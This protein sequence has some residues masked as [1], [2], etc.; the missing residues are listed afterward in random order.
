MLRQPRPSVPHESR[1][2]QVARLAYRMAQRT[3]RR[4]SHRN[5]PHTY[6][7]AQ[8]AA[9]TF[10]VF[11][12]HK[13]YRDGEELL[14]A[15]DS[16]RQ[17]LQLASVPDHSTLCRM[18][19]KLNRR[20]LL[21]QLRYLVDQ[22][23]AGEDYIALDSTS[24][25]QSQASSYFQTRRGG[26]LR[27]WY[28][29][30]YAVGTAS[31]LILAAASDGGRTLN[32]VCFLLPL[33]QQARYAA[34]AHTLF[35]ADAGFDAQTVDAHDVIPPIRRGN[36]LVAPARR[37]R[38]DLVSQ[39]RL[40]GLFGQRWKVETVNSVTKRLFGESV[41]SRSRRLKRREPIFKAVV[42]NLHR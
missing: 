8:V 35:L 18:Y 17:V 28:R 15:C 16:I 5:S 41:R 23:A 11:Y 13:S 26:R 20:R 38:A 34:H 7:Q 9:C 42:Y 10:M 39:A 19:H 2:V 24:F 21:R 37:A 6:T 4:Y 27:D 14:W 30:A 3:M 25:S 31:Q 12:F 36:K 1:Y 29:G 32:D 22:H 40:D 33:K